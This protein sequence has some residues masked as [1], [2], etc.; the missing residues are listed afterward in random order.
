MPESCS[1]FARG[2]HP[3][4]GNGD[5]PLRIAMLAPPWIAVPP[6]GYGGIET[7]VAISRTRSSRGETR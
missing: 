6:P 2:A 3:G 4:G 1:K 5:R 7:V